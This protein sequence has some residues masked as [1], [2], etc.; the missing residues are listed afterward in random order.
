MASAGCRQICQPTTSVSCPPARWSSVSPTQTIG[1][2]PA[3]TAATAFSRTSSSVSPWFCRRSRMTQDHPARARIAQHRGDDVPGMRA[4]R[5]LVAIL[6]AQPRPRIPP[7]PVPPQADGR[8]G[9]DQ[10]FAGQPGCPVRPRR[11]PAPPPRR[12]ARASSSSRRSVAA[13]DVINRAPSAPRAPRQCYPAS[14]GC[15][16]PWSASCTPKPAS[17][18]CPATWC[19]RTMRHPWPGCDE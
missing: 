19:R 14:A 7:G 12:A 18:A 5:R 13:W 15:R 2:R 17:R 1:V 11:A 3:S 6:S 4:L 16:R 9:A 10:Q 8:R